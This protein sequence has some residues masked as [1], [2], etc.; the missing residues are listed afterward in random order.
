[1]LGGVWVT[2]GVHKGYAGLIDVKTGELVWLNA[3]YQMGGD[4]RTPEGAVKRV[5]QLLEG[6]PGQ[7]VAT[8]GAR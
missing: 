2:S 1:L 3:D 8:S 4:V 6:F 5:G 7:N